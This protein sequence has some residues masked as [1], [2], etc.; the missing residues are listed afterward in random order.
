[1][2]YS[3][4]SPFCEDSS[5]ICALFPLV[6]LASSV[7]PKWAGIEPKRVQS[8]DFKRFRKCGGAIQNI[9]K[10]R[11]TFGKVPVWANH[12]VQ[13]KM[14]REGIGFGLEDSF[15]SLTLHVKWSDSVG[16]A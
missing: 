15:R 9:M 16:H 7:N 14:L 12:L 3:L 1:M 10:T 8:I 2:G 11:E 6:S 5:Q 13:G 4:E